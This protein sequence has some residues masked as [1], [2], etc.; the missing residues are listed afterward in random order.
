MG[1][2]STPEAIVSFDD[3][4]VVEVVASVQFDGLSA[5]SIFSVCTHWAQ[6]LRD[7]FP[8]FSLQP[9]YEVPQELFQKP[10]APSISF[11]FGAHPPLPRVWLSGQDGEQSELMQVQQD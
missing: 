10:T 8:N 2:T 5:A 7:E 9:P 1:D 11:Q 4:P 6:S 3:P